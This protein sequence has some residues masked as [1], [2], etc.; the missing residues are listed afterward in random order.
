VR[1]IIASDLIEK[2]HSSE[3][4]FDHRFEQKCSTVLLEYDPRV[5]SRCAAIVAPLPHIE[6]SGES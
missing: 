6:L 5:K 4:I 2:P 1:H 3:R